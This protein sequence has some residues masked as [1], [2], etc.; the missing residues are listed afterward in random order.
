MPPIVL[1]WLALLATP[2][3]VLTQGTH[4]ATVQALQTELA[5]R[6]DYTGPTDGIYGPGTAAGVSAF[7]RSA[8]APEDGVAGPLVLGDI[9]AKVAQGAPVLRQGM[10]TLAVRDL[11][12]LLQADGIP[13]S[14]DGVFGPATAAA[15]RALQTERGIAVD[16]VAG[17]QTWEAL[18]SRSY[19]V[20]SGDTLANIAARFALPVGNLVAAN[21]GR[22]EILSGQ[23]LML[24]YAGWY[25]GSTQA[26]ASAQP[27]S[28][29]PASSP[30]ASGSSA[31]G[32]G[33]A[34]A[35]GGSSGTGSLIP[36]SSLAQW[37][38]AG[39]PDISVIVVAEDQAAETALAKALP[40]GMLLAL[41]QNLWTH[42]SGAGKALLAT[43]NTPSGKTSA[44]VW[45]GTAKSPAL[46]S[47]LT[48]GDRVLV[49]PVLPPGQ[50]AAQAAG[51]ASFI[52]PVHGSDLAALQNL[53]AQLRSAGYALVRPTGF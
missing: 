11:Q 3:A 29:Q 28:S 42:Y 23:D 2:Q 45:L 1:I 51:G 32:S 41:P 44:I 34:A 19:T 18:F 5:M 22:T 35:S 16:G 43:A 46:T 36:G 38:A 47:L 15:V 33:S 20:S 10:S 26:A 48:G 17:P 31:A 8:G 12:G 7:E 6:L 13:C 37:G 25:G 53:A 49:A 39:T 21:G 24:P 40:A 27:S 9:A 30:S 52:V 50:V 4:G 14:V